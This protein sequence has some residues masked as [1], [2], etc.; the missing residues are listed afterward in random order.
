MCFSSGSGMLS[1]G[2]VTGDQISVHM[3]MYTMGCRYGKPGPPC[4]IAIDN[5]H[6][7]GIGNGR[8]FYQCDVIYVFSSSMVMN[9]VMN[10]GCLRESRPWCP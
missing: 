2:R 4:A 6:R 8:S 1:S 10:S 3:Y 7:K 5:V 9:L